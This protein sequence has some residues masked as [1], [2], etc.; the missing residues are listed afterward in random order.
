MGREPNHSLGHT[1]DIKN[2]WRYTTI[3]PLRLHS[4]A[5]TRLNVCCDLHGYDAVQS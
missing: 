4:V 3:P 2:G 5:L 1:A